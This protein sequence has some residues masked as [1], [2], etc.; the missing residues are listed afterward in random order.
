MTYPR[1]NV[2]NIAKSVYTNVKK[3]YKRKDFKEFSYITVEPPTWAK[4][5]TFIVTFIVTVLLCWWAITNQID[6][7]YDPLK[8]LFN[9]RNNGYRY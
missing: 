4:W 7:V 1:F 5:V 9:K 2:D 3:E 6:S 8:E